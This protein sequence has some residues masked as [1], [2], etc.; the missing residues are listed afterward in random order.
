LL[1]ANNSAE[2][3]EAFIGLY[4]NGD[5]LPPRIVMSLERSV[6][7]AKDTYMLATVMY[8]SNLASPAKFEDVIWRTVTF[9]DLQFAVQALERMT[10][11][12]YKP[13][14]TTIGFL[15]TQLSRLRELKRKTGYTQAD[16]NKNLTFL[17][18][19]V[20]HYTP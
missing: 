6:K 10:D 5:W 19:Y 15:R 3:W 18:D 7:S 9:E 4:K 14:S 17:W 2:A 20:Q 8:S 12:G 13:T 16:A 1:R 11:L